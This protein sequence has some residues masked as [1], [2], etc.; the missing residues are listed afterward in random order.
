MQKRNIIWWNTKW[1]C[2]YSQ[3]PHLDNLEAL[4]LNLNITKKYS[5]V[6]KTSKILST[7]KK[8]LHM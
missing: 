5:V 4:L 8:K 1:T 2:C 7:I 3:D 6:M